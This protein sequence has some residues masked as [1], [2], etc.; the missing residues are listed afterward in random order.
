MAYHR[1]LRDQGVV[2]GGGVRVAAPQS[3]RWPCVA[4]VTWLP[5][6]HTKVTSSTPYDRPEEEGPITERCA[7]LSSTSTRDFVPLGRCK[8]FVASVLVTLDRC[9]KF[10]YG[11]CWLLLSVARSLR[12][13]EDWGDE[14]RGSSD[15]GY[16]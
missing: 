13:M 14:P 1:V 2:R 16:S 3:G 9:K 10:C 7:N 5:F 12:C 15:F 4:P 8:K 6:R 11:R